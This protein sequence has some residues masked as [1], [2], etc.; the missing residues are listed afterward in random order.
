[1][2]SAGLEGKG[3]RR[4]LPQIYFTDKLTWKEE[5]LPSLLLASLSLKWVCTVRVAELVDALR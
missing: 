5:T 1:M 4:N 2:A 3:G